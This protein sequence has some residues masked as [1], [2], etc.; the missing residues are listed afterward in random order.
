[1]A[2]QNE[3]MANSPAHWYMVTLL[4][5]AADQKSKLRVADNPW[6]AIRLPDSSVN[7]AVLDDLPDVSP[8]WAFRS[9][10]PTNTALKTKPL[11]PIKIITRYF[12]YLI[13]KMTDHI[14]TMNALKTAARALGSGGVF[15]ET[16]GVKDEVC[17]DRKACN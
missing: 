12:D 6:A 5:F 15:K 16:G 17:V 8:W 11:I 13:W 9:S 10:P 4:L 14:G 1:M 3:T 7:A 2:P